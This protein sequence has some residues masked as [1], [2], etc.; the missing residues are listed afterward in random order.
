MRDTK[1]TNAAIYIPA[2][3]TVVIAETTKTLA[4]KFGGAS[5]LLVEKTWI[6]EDGELIKEKVVILRSWFA[7]RKFLLSTAFIIDL[8]VKVREKCE[9][10]SISV[11][12]E[13]EMLLI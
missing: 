11:E 13:G 12:V 2:V 9:Q 8:A 6:D 1:D 5:N 4:E 10:V 7:Q 3:Y